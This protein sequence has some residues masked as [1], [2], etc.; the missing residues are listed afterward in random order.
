[1]IDKIKDKNDNRVYKLLLTV[2]FMFLFGFMNPYGLDNILY[3]FNSYGNEYINKL[4]IEML[5]PIIGFHNTVQN[6]YGNILFILIMFVTGI[7]IFFK[8][9]K[10]ELRHILLSLGVTVLALL[11]I[12]RIQLYIIG[13]IPFTSAYLKSYFHSLPENENKYELCVSFK[14]QYIFMVIFLSLY[15]IVFLC[16]VNGSTKFEIENGVDKILKYKDAKNSKI[17]VGYGYGSYLIYRGLTPYM[18]GR[19]EV[20]LKNNNHKEDILKEYYLLNNGYLDY[21]EFISKYEFGYMIIMKN[22]EIYREAIEDN[23]YKVIY[24]E[25]KYSVFKRLNKN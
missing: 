9:G 3:V 10:L 23:N 13:S 12:R 22:D 24:K 4:V 8:K 7:Y 6:I 16:T 18:D 17:Y 11:N 14:K 1:M 5:P 2:V 19:A 15:T 21:S 25:K 20:F